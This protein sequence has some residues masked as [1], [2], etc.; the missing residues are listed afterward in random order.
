MAKDFGDGTEVSG[1]GNQ[2]SGRVSL[3]IFR[4]CWL[5]VRV[6]EGAK[7]FWQCGDDIRSYGGQVRGHPNVNIAIRFAKSVH[8]HG[9]HLP[10]ILI[11]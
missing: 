4:Q 5:G 9:G 1:G 11:I 10:H 8:P 2:P 6:Q 3:V 7:L